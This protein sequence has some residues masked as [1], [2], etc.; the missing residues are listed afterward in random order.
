MP[1]QYTLFG[2]P[3]RPMHPRKLAVLLSSIALFAILTLV[4]TLPNSIT[5]GPSLSRFTDHKITIPKLPSTLSPSILNPFRQVAHAPP[6]QKNSTS[7]EASW[8][9]NWSWLTPFSSSFTLDE[10][11]SILPPMKERSPIYTYYDHTVKMDQERRDAENTLLLTWRRAWW[12]QGFKPVVLSPAEAMRSPFYTELQ[13]KNLEAP[14]NIAISRWLAWESMGTG[15]LC[16]TLLFPMG[17]HN[18]PLLS[19]LRRGEYPVLTRFDNLGRGLFAGSKVDITAAIKQALSNPELKNAKDFIG[20]VEPD[21]FE[22]DPKHDS[23]AYYSK[24]TVKD[25]Y[26]KIADEINDGGAKGLVT[27]NKL[28]LAHLVRSVTHVLLPHTRDISY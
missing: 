13:M 17:E 6:V 2:R 19:F 23:L 10:N 28:I 22:I 24:A 1:V 26:A 5:A 8:Y 16:E 25:K 4:F 27:L 21:T 7:G 12:A 18:D 11:R 20:A 14:L 9:S 15:M 3:I